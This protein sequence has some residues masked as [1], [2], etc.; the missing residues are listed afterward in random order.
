MQHHDTEF[1]SF[2]KMLVEIPLSSSELQPGASPPSVL[3]WVLRLS[4][5]RDAVHFANL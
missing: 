5:Q 2:S 3:L 1:A 4:Q